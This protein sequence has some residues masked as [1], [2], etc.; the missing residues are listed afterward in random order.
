[1]SKISITLDNNALFLVIVLVT[2]RVFNRKQ[3]DHLK[4]SYLA[5]FLIVILLLKFQIKDG[6]PFNF[7]F[8]K[9]SPTNEFFNL[10]TIT[11]CQHITFHQNLVWLLPI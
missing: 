7:P 6:F 8:L 3:R 4:F 9:R 11:L 5:I 2:F 10:E 1:M